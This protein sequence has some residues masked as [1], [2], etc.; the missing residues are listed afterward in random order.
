M[1]LHNKRIINTKYFDDVTQRGKN[2]TDCFFNFKRHLAINHLGEIIDITL[3][4]SNTPPINYLYQNAT[5]SW[6]WHFCSTQF[7]IEHE[8]KWKNLH[9][10]L[11]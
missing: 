8:Y 11:H 1:F 7:H 9:V 5:S 6:K 4:S 10:L 2:S 3:T